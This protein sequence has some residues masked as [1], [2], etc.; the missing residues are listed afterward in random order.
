MKV[1][2]EEE[3]IILLRMKMNGETNKSAHIKRVY[4]E[5]SGSDEL[6][7]RDMVRRIDSLA[8][9]SLDVRNLLGQLVDMQRAPIGLTLAAATLL[10]LYPSVQAPVQAKITKYIDMHGVEAIL[11]AGAL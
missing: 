11:K 4:F 6:A 7:T 1:S 9:S 3:E 8:E 10:L 2:V 5:G